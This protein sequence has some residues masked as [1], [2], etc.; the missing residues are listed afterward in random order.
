M[1]ALRLLCVV[2]VLSVVPATGAAAQMS[3]TDSAYNE[4]RRED[5]RQ[6]K[7]IKFGIGGAVLLVGGGA[8]VVK[9]IRGDA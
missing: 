4:K 7:W 9:K 1:K 8:W 2:A 6:W 3:G 5:R